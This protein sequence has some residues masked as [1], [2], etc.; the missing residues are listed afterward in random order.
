MFRN[1]HLESSS[2]Y[3]SVSL[4]AAVK[5]NLQATGYF[6]VKEETSPA[7]TPL[8]VL[9]RKVSGRPVTIYLEVTK[10]GLW[11]N[12]P[13]YTFTSTVSHFDFVEQETRWTRR[14]DII[15]NVV[16]ALMK[17]SVWPFIQNK[18]FFSVNENCRSFTKKKGLRDRV[19]EEFQ[20]ALNP[21]ARE[22]RDIAK[23]RELEKTASA[24]LA[25]GK[26]A[27]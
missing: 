2:H 18:N 27:G 6:F 15:V 10:T 14:K 19:T 12:P 8:L 26:K 16:A 7:G 3:M 25:R 5:N 9:T 23:K 24:L 21:K 4:K 13:K 20:D 1:E 17:A 22:K 11:I